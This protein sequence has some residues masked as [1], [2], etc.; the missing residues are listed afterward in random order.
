MKLHIA[1]LLS[2]ATFAL[3]FVLGSTHS[4]AQNAYAT[5]DGSFNVS[6]I[7][8]A[9]NK[10]IATIGGFH[11]PYGVA[12]SP[13]GGKVYV[14]NSPASAGNSNISVMDPKRIRWSPP[15]LSVVSRSVWE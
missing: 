4:L 9:N 13:D 7:N 3:F 15:F 14:T 5:N 2:I 8:T 12:V 6:V 1:G 10:V 11:E